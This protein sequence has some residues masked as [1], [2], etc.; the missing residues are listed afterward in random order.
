MPRFKGF[1]RTYLRSQANHLDPV[2]MIGKPG[3][4]A[5]V[6]EKID[7]S[8]NDHEL[9]KIRF[10]EYDRDE[11]KRMCVTIAGQLSAE[12]CGKIG[13]VGIFYREHPESGQHKIHLPEAR[14]RQ[15]K[16]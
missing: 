9:I 4:T 3:L 6:I 5:S 8:L 2:V 16:Y 10:L 1:Q 11:I 12:F 15:E 13:H 14:A 7:A